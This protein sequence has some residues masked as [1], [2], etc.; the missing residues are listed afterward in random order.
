MELST[1][2][3]SRCKRSLPNESFIYKE[4]IHLTCE[5]CS[6]D[7]KSLKNFC[8][9]CGIRPCFNF[10]EEKSGIRCKKHSLP[11]MVDV[12]NK[13]CIVCKKTRTAFNY[14]GET[15]ATH[16]SACKLPT[17]VNV[18]NKRCI[19]C[20]KKIPIFN[21]EGETKATHCGVCKLPT[22][23]NVKDKKC[24]VCEKTRPTFNYEGETK[25]THCSTCKLPTMVDI[26]NKRCIVC[27]KK[28][29]AF[30]YE[31]ETKATHCGVCKLPTM[32]DVKSKRCIVCEKTRPTFNYHR[33]TNATHCSACKL[34]TMVDIKHP[35]CQLCKTRASYGIPLNFPTR[36][37][38]HK[39]TGMISKPRARCL[40]KECKNNAL[41]GINRPIHCE[42]HK[43]LN[44][45]NLVERKCVR[46]E[47]IDVVDEKGLCINFC[48]TIDQFNQYRKHI[49]REEERIT[50]ILTAEC[51][52][53]T[54]IDV[55]LEEACKGDNERPDVVYDCGTHIV[56]EETDESQHE[57]RC[58]LG[59][60]N[61][62][63]TICQIFGGIPVI[64]IRYNPHK[65]KENGKEVKIP[66]GKKEEELIR[67]VKHYKENKP[68]MTWSVVYLFYDENDT[69]V[70][71][72]DPDDSKTYECKIC[73]FPYYL[74]SMFL[75]HVKTKHK[76]VEKKILKVKQRVICI[77]KK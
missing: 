16:C 60:F 20:E 67:W 50:K 7:R 75:H 59:E 5:A 41:Y 42:D 6:E 18:K 10:E 12:I 54:A 61:R 71:E 15:K 68:V 44:D 31:G 51:G 46:C 11:N 57:H 36:C 8:E 53:P 24:V 17:M 30:N 52:E 45:I 64:F 55:R 47:K 49:K 76:E 62:M 63:K 13:R 39:E 56:I 9:I 28:I 22:M 23:V 74:K 38:Q 4:K 26:K 70:Y 21:Y 37:V 65:H 2:K 73:S 35:K 33:E 19:V 25:A 27:E 48:N 66:Q 1:K 69:T 34:P 14:E 32:I 72:I 43:D 40:K 3:C 77:E 29:P 58:Q